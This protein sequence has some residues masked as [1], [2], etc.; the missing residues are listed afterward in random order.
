LD[1]RTANP[2][3]EKLAE[4]MGLEMAVVLAAKIDRLK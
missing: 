1:R 4:K 2:F 3:E